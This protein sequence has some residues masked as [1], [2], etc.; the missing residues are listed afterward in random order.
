MN[1]DNMDIFQGQTEACGGSPKY[2]HLLVHILI[3]HVD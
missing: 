3:V 2:Q 1:N